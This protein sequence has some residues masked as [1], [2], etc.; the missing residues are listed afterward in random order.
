[1]SKP[2]P[3][4]G[5][6]AVSNAPGRFATRCTEPEDARDPAPGTNL[7]DER[8]VSIISRNRS[9]DVPFDQSLNPYRGCEHGCVYCYARP[10][11]SYL[12]LS[13]GL[14]FESE[15]FVK[16]NA[17][18]RLRATLM[19]PRYECRPITIG[20][21]TDAYQ[22]A[23]RS[24]RITRSVLEVLAEFRHPFSIITK[25][26]LIER[27][28]D[29]LGEMAADGLCSVAIS[30][31]TLQDDVKRL[32][33]PR[34]PSATRRLRTIERLAAAGVPVTLMLAPVIPALTDHE[35]E[36]IL[37]TAAAAGADRATWVLLRLPHE[38]APL[39]REWL[40]AHYPQRAA[41]VMSLV[42]QSRGGRDYDAAWGRRQ[43]GT[44]E[45]AGLIARR[46]AMAR[47]RAGYGEG[48]RPLDTSRFRR[49]HPAGQLALTL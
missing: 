38:V 32:L 29:I 16:T 11:H 33:E 26:A 46:F 17:A 34:A 27:D 43:R 35:I 39:F 36:R 22:P 3:Q 4:P 41:R 45:Y 40:E 8:A 37:K 23:E 2:T 25:S 5:R 42:R 49:P 15:I 21:N 13:P 9:P 31:P 6:G 14:D 30:L 1:M 12:D 24:R 47:R 7:H 20:A 48:E 10:T 44:G 28:L 19:N 18:D